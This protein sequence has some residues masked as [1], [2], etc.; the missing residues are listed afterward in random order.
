M[1]VVS[2]L[3]VLPRLN[4]SFEKRTMLKKFVQGVNAVGDIGVIHDGFDL[5][6]A[7]VGLIQCWQHEK[8]KQL[9]HLDLRQ[10]VINRTQNSHVCTSDSNLFLYANPVNEPL[11]YLR[12]SFNGVFPNTGMYFDT[13]PNNT[14]WQQISKHLNLKIQDYKKGGD[15]ILIC[16]Q[17]DKGWSMGKLSLLSWLESTCI[18][19]RT[20]TDRP[21]HI[22]FHPK[23]KNTR[24]CL[25]N[26]NSIVKKFKN[27]F[28]T[29]SNATIETD[30]FNCYAVVNHNSSSIVGPIICGYNAYITDPLHSQCAEVSNLDFSQIENPMQFDRHRWLNR[31]AT[32]HWNFEELENGSYW[33]H[34]RKY[35]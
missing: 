3:K 32:F 2:Y 24:E 16:A 21:I 19:I 18:T 14:R 13:E 11:H 20:H 8:G 25:K 4:N 9:P 6:N 12:Y 10:R 27:T 23:D 5:V 15:H 1:K 30:L 31:L 7:D 17:R 26:F 28:I 33:R 35:I 22:R 34:V 29:D